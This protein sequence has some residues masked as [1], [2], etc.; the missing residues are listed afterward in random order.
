MRTYEVTLKCDDINNPNGINH[1]TKY[2]AH[3]E[4]ETFNKIYSLLLNN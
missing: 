2:V 4:E 3:I 1:H